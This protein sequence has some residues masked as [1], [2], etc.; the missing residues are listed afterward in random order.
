[1]KALVSIRAELAA[2]VR[3]VNAAFYLLPEEIR[4]DPAS[5]DPL[6]TEVDAACLSDDRDRAMAAIRAWR[7]HWLAT[8]EEAARQAERLAPFPSQPAGRG[9]PKGHGTLG[10]GR[11]A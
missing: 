9:T 10:G 2:A 7:D 5:F 1:M 8:F 11:R 4:P 6:Q 3:A